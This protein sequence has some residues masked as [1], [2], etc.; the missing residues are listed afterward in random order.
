MAKWK[1][2]PER[3]QEV[4]GPN[5]RAAF[6]E[7]TP[8][9]AMMVFHWAEARDGDIDALYFMGGGGVFGDYTNHPQRYHFLLKAAKLGHIE[10]QYTLGTLHRHCAIDLP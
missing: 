5:G 6:A 9:E 3:V 10:A 8:L 4:L 7:A 1:A 2:F